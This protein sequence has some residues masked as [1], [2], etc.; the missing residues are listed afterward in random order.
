M[1]VRQQGHQA[2]SAR[3]LWLLIAASRVAV[4]TAT[5]PVLTTG[6]AGRD[7]W[8]ASLLMTLAAVI[9]SVLLASFVRRLGRQSFAE[10]SLDVWGAWLGRAMTLGLCGILL[11]GAFAQLRTFTDLIT[12]TALPNTPDWTLSII[13]VLP[14]TFVAWRGLDGLGRSAEIVITLLALTFVVIFPLVSVPE[15]EWR[16]IL[17]VMEHGLS[18]ILSSIPVGLVWFLAFSLTALA[19]YPHVDQRQRILPT[20]IMGNVVAGAVLVLVSIVVVGQFGPAEAAKLLSPVYS[21]VKNLQ[22]GG[23]VRRME[24][25]VVAIWVPAAGL[26]GAFLLWAAARLLAGITSL[27]IRH[28]VLLGGAIVVVAAALPHPNLF[29]LVTWQT[30]LA[31]PL[32]L[33]I[34]AVIISTWAMDLIR[35]PGRHTSRRSAGGASREK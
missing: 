6:R 33:A 2:I 9:F 35:R 16:W 12:V 28:A 20:L 24:I 17:P 31:L 32:I 27:Q 7:A 5:L 29:E 26:A 22:I 14:P 15:L 4:I 30:R 13:A 18:P 10:Y 8:I 3:Q 1:R 21:L 11:A 23:I 34:L 25:L 19:A